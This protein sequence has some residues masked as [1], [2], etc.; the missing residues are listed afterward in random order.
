MALNSP[1]SILRKLMTEDAAL[2]M[3]GVY[4]V[5]GAKLVEQGGGRTVFVSGFSVVGSRLGLPDIGLGALDEISAAARNI[6]EAVSIP[7]IVDGDDGYGDVKNVV[8]T[9]HRYERMGAAAI[10]LEDQRWPKRCG[11][12]AGK[13]IVPASEIVAKIRA[14]AGERIEPSTMIVGRTDARAVE[15][16]DEALRRADQ[17]LE[18]GADALFIEAPQT[19]EEMER[20][21]RAFGH[22]PLFVNPLPGGKSPILTPGEYQV[23]GFSVIGY[24]ITPLFQAVGA[25]RAGITDM[26]SGRCALLD[27]GMSFADYQRL[28]GL[29]GWDALADRYPS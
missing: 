9:V 4:D 2:I 5:L 6:I 10:V 3:I 23:L 1:G 22:V 13:A 14:A 26:L 24:G 29:R 25:M 7:V 21:G 8:H 16:L 12:L 27:D 20:I 28:V 17:F 19:V 15:G 18:A 11:H